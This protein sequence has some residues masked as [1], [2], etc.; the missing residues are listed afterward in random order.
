MSS[1]LMPRPG[2]VEDDGLP[3]HSWTPD[4]HCYT[5]GWWSR[6]IPEQKLN[7]LFKNVKMP[8]LTILLVGITFAYS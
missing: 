2:D 4:D 3:E 6:W 5:W 7:S 8:V 1:R